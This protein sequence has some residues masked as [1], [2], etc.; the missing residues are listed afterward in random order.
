MQKVPVPFLGALADSAVQERQPHR[1]GSG[2][3]DLSWSSAGGGGSKPSTRGVVDA[4][5]ALI[6]IVSLR[7]IECRRVESMKESVLETVL[8][9]ITT[10]FLVVMI[11]ILGGG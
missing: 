7:R 4:T 10:L 1:P 5:V 8:I 6:R 9:S 2:G 11:A 3:A